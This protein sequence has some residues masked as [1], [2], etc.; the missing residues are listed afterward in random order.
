MDSLTSRR[1]FLKL[2]L[3]GSLALRISP[4][5][6]SQTLANGLLD[7]F[8]TEIPG[9]RSVE[10]EK[11]RGASKTLV[12]VRQMHNVEVPFP[13]EDLMEDGVFISEGHKNVAREI[14]GIYEGIA[15]TQKDIYSIVRYLMSN[16]NL[17]EVF[18]EGVSLD[19]EIFLNEYPNESIVFQMKEVLASGYFGKSVEDLPRDIIYIAGAELI[20]ASQLGLNI[21][22]T[23]SFGLN[24]LVIETSRT[25]PE[26]NDIGNDLREDL[27]LDLI[28]LSESPLDVMIYGGYHKWSDN[29]QDWNLKN[30]DKKYSLIEVTPKSYKVRNVRN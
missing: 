21:R 14:I 5:Y 23:E 8:P 26:L 24:K 7:D 27:A 20:L 29:I 10:K 19:S 30:P 3:I 6:N 1:D 16:N 4:K 18:A 15:N 11:I 28:S 9:A 13:M 22:A 2:G 17:G 25:D 12:H